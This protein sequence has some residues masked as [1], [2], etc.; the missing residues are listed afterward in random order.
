VVDVGPEHGSERRPRLGAKRLVERFEARVKMAGEAL[1]LFAHSEIAHADVPQALVQVGEHQIEQLLSER[2]GR[3]A[4]GLQSAHHQG[5]VQADHLEAPLGGVRDAQIPI[6]RRR[7]R[8]VY[9]IAV[10]STGTLAS[11]A[12]PGVGPDAAEP[13]P[14]APRDRR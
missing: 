11:G 2:G 13:L 6:K 9:Q 7:S 4:R 12:V 10:Q 5:D 1:D 3:W 8:L 14:G